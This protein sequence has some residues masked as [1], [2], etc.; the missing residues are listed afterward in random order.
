MIKIASSS[1][2]SQ[3]IFSISASHKLVFDDLM[4]SVLIIATK[5]ATAIVTLGW[6]PE[7]ISTSLIYLY[8]KNFFS[9]LRHFQ[10]QNLQ[11]TIFDLDYW[12]IKKK[13][14]FASSQ[15]TMDE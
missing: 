7:G 14:M 9:W 15:I 10:N 13:V 6:C 12:W 1:Y 11:E 4:P 3:F 8:F 2:Q 5:N